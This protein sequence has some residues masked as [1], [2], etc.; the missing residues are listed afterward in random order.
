MTSLR[1]ILDSTPNDYGD[2]EAA[3][4]RDTAQ[5]LL[6][7]EPLQGRGLGGDDARVAVILPA[8]DD[9][10]VIRAWSET[11][12]ASAH[13]H[14][15]VLVVA[16]NGSL[17]IAESA[18]DVLLAPSA[19]VW[20]AINGAIAKIDCDHLVFAGPGHFPS[21]ASLSELVRRLQVLPRSVLLPMTFGL[22]S[23]TQLQHPE[24]HR[25]RRLRR[26][27]FP[28]NL[29]VGTEHLKRLGRGC[30][31]LDTGGG[32]DDLLTVVGEGPIGMARETFI[33]A[34]GFD[35]RID[36]WPHQLRW[37]TA[38]AAALG[39]KVIP[40]YAAAFGRKGPRTR[41]AVTGELALQRCLQ[42]NADIRPL[43]APDVPLI[44]VRAS[45]MA[46]RRAVDVPPSCSSRKGKHAFAAGQ[47][48][49]ADA[50]LELAARNGCVRPADVRLLQA[51]ALRALGDYGRAHDALRLAG[52]ERSSVLEETA[53]LLAEEGHY[54]AAREVIDRARALGRRSRLEHVLEQPTSSHV[55]RGRHHLA[56]GLP[57]LAA[58][59][60]DFALLGSPDDAVARHERGRLLLAL[61]DPSGAASELE[62][63]ARTDGLDPRMRSEMYTCLG[64]AR[65]ELGALRQAKLAWDLAVDAHAGNAGARIALM[66]LTETC[67]RLQGLA[68]DV[69]VDPTANAIEGWLAPEEQKLLAQ[70]ANAAAALGHDFLEVGSY[71]GK[72][73]VVIAAALR[74]IGAQRILYA[75]DPHEDFPEGKHETSL[76]ILETNLSTRGLQPWVRIVKA[77]STDVRIDAPFALVF[78]DGDHSYESVAA[79]YRHFR[80][81]IVTGG[82]L[83]FHDYSRY[84]PGVRTVVQSALDDP[85]FDF[86]SH[87]GGLIAL[88]KRGSPPQ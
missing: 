29:L 16:G 17:G 81:A 18:L 80:D 21:R 48:E 84:W 23:W 69:V 65:M 28:E 67:E 35:P 37:I 60:L 14:G 66:R 34:G 57:K 3:Y 27:V 44:E 71:C 59:D 62:A 86:V 9:A 19:P 5:E 55:A 70:L 25:D 43:T 24:F 77:R 88:R 8:L 64:N 82:F 36:S 47:F 11:E 49:R 1:M 58:R 39:N 31:I 63:V 56:R 33:A 26:A 51:R 85:A 46:A 53:L 78:I 12:L 32:L 72:S 4:F 38:R 10:A 20:S 75:V 74:A 45:S 41:V 50:E 87:R 83:A 54:G 13:P 61:G 30:T 7:F 73:T 40:V 52:V 22:G 42:E 2:Q 6:S 79:D 76:P 15:V 68:D